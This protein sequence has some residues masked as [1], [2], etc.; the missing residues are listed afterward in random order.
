M[1][2]KSIQEFHQSGRASVRIFLLLTLAL[3]L[4]AGSTSLVGAGKPTP[5]PPPGPTPTPKPAGQTVVSL[6]FDDGWA[7]QYTARAIFAAH[8]MKGTFYVNSSTISSGTSYLSWSQLT[9][10]AS[11]G[12]EIAGHSLTHANLKNLKGYALLHEICDDRVAL[13]NHGFQ[14]TSFA[15]PFGNYNS[16]TEMA[17]AQCGYNSARTVSGSMETI[18]PMDPYALRA[19]T[20]IKSSTSLAEMEGYVTQVENA[21]GGWVILFFHHICNG[22]DPLS[23]TDTNLS[24]LMDWLQPRVANGTVVKTINT[25][26]GGTIKPPVSAQ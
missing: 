5:T 21:K 23:V 2:M 26:I 22:C 4:T 19:Y 15:Y 10:L 16:S 7:D 24:A 25:V 9:D 20:N 17:V 13:F 8:G 18:P 12:N 11:D 1:L 14:V 6:T 3:L